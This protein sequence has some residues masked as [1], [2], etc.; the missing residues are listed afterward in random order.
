VSLS[1]IY[2]LGESEPLQ[3]RVK[4]E[5]LW[6]GEVFEVWRSRFLR[7]A[8]CCSRECYAAVRLEFSRFIRSMGSVRVVRSAEE[9]PDMVR[10]YFRNRLEEALKVLPGD[11]SALAEVLNELFALLAGEDEVEG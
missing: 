10:E 2:R 7:G 1:N 3:S 5:C 6:C 11:S 4:C 9:L 8:K